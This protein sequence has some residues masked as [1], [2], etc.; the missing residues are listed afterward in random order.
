MRVFSK[1]KRVFISITSLFKDQVEVYSGA[2]LV[3]QMVK[4]LT[5][6][7]ENWVW[8][9]G[10]E[11][12]LKE[13]MATHSRILAWKK[14]R[15]EKPGGLQFMGLQRVRHDWATNMFKCLLKLTVQTED[16]LIREWVTILL[17][18]MGT[19]SR[20]PLF[21]SLDHLPQ[22]NQEW[23]GPEFLERIKC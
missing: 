16:L 9:L 21:H 1:L 7:Q 18:M 8:S 4:N 11:D 3:A 22:H 12:P 5:A 15:T 13:G 2:S 14:P 6:M 19:L 10:W 17:R 20:L 23:G